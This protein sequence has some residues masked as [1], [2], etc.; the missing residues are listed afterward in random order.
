MSDVA[1][2]DAPRRQRN[3]RGQGHRLRDEILAGATTILEH[4][5]DEHAV[6]LRAVARRIG[7]T[8]PSITTHF[9]DPAAIIDAVVAEQLGGLAERLRSAAHS[10]ADPV[11]ALQAAWAAYLDFGR[12][13][14]AHYRVIFER[15]FLTVWDDQQRPMTETAPLFDATTEMMIGLL[16]TCIDTATSTSADAFADSVAIWYYTH[17]LVALPAT[18]TSFAWPDAHTHLA[19]GITNLAHLTPPAR[20]RTPK[21]RPPNP[22]RR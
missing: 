11:D 18:I 6:T 3:P 13:N 22:A 20:T 19:T 9:P 2:H 12:A 16:Q 14:P 15:R 5:G 4:S 10:T 21:R 17:G 7:I 1:A 8:A